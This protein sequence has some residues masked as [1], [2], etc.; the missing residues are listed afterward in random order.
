MLIQGHWQLQWH[1]EVDPC[2]RKLDV[3]VYDTDYS[4]EWMWE[5]LRCPECRH[6]WAGVAPVGYFGIECPMCGKIDDGY[7][8]SAE[9]PAT[10]DERRLMYEH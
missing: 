6:E 5:H 8:W 10:T 3:Q 1:L 4:G 7:I 2:G 9:D